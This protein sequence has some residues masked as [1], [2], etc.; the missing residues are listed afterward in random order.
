MK[1]GAVHPHDVFAMIDIVF[2]FSGGAGVMRLGLVRGKMAMRDGVIVVVGRIRLMDV[3]G[4]HR[5]RERQEWR[6]DQHS[7]GAVEPGHDRIIEGCVRRVNRERV[8][9]R[10]VTSH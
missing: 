5:R 6:D 3:L 10:S 2:D 8:T 4:S 9:G 1:N 7:S